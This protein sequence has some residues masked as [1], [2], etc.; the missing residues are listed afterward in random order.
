MKYLKIKVVL[1]SVFIIFSSL[2]TFAYAEDLPEEVP[3][4]E[5][6][7]I[8]HNVNFTIRDGANIVW[9]GSVPLPDA[10][11]VDLNDKDGNPHSINSRSVLSVLTQA[12]ELSEDFNIS[13][14][15]YYTSFGALYM[16][17][18]TST[19]GGEK[20]DNWQYTVNNAYAFIGM[21]QNVLTGDENVYIYFGTQYRHSLSSSTINTNETLTVNTEEY[22]Y[23]DNTWKIRSGV[24]VGLTQ[25]DPS[26]PWSPT[27]VL[28]SPVDANGVATFTSIPVG[29]YDVGVKEDYYYPTYPLTI[30]NPPSSE[31]GGGSAM[32]IFNTEKAISYLLNNQSED[33][34]FGESDMYTDWAIIALKA[35]GYNLNSNTVI[36]Y[37]ERNNTLSTSITD[38]ERR[39]MAILALGKN[40]YGY[41]GVNYIEAIIK[42]WDGAQFG[43][44]NL[45]NDD[46]FALIPLSASGYTRNDEIIKKGIEFILSK[47][48]TNGSWE[49]SVD[50]T[51]AGVQALTKFKSVDGVSLALSN[52]S[53]F[54]TSKQESTGGFGNVY[55]TSWALQAMQALGKDW[56]TNNKHP[57]D[58]LAN[59]QEEDGALSPANDTIQNRLWSTSYALPAALSKTWNDIMIEVGKPEISN[60]TE[61]KTL[62]IK[63]EKEEEIVTPTE[64]KI[65]EIPKKEIVKKQEKPKIKKVVVK[66]IEKKDTNIDEIS[67]LVAN[68][69][70]SGISIFRPISDW[71]IYL[72]TKFIGMFR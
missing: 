64:I 66:D 46:I 47:Q 8:V 29:T 57:L 31:S 37:L 65:V 27:E 13:N 58:Y 50:V 35:G 11:S 20:C 38:N 3:P 32:S 17:C 54:L 25:P 39:A 10:G 59:N 36:S 60:N 55:A 49:D 34:S 51:S 14:L 21:D 33:G 18:M 5:P 53:D 62:E 1:A 6:A 26:N 70:N 7:P 9:Q 30:V 2:F 12:D 43:D 19:V 61:E 40:P 72:F 23:E 15:E 41:H 71:I 24:T 56:V 68:A 16:K 45:V 42:K 67:P 48:K 69:N 22:N 28:L 52:A 63:V 44:A 4:V